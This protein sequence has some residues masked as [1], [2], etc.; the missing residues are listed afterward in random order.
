MRV[1][2]GNWYGKWIERSRFLCFSF[3]FAASAWLSGRSYRNPRA[4]KDRRSNYIC[5]LKRCKQHFHSSVFD[6]FF[7]LSCLCQFTAGQKSTPSALLTSTASRKSP[8]RLQA[9][10]YCICFRWSR[11]RV[12]LREEGVLCDVWRSSVRGMTLVS[13]RVHFLLFHNRTPVFFCLFW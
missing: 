12:S 5:G 10:V 4:V 2:F 3:K 1:F 8:V 9:R 7:C 6:A 13:L 11:P